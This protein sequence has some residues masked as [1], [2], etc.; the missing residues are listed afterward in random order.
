ME[1]SQFTSEINMLKIDG[2]LIPAKDIVLI[3]VKP[4]AD[5]M[6][7]GYD[8]SQFRVPTRQIADASIS[9]TV[10]NLPGETAFVKL[11]DLLCSGAPCEVELSDP[12]GMTIHV[13]CGVAQFEIQQEREEVVGADVILRPT[14]FQPQD[15]DR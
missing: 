3:L 8:F 11:R 7:V 6:L 4:E 15:T 1:L 14:C 5:Q 9:F 2:N 13:T 12:D 10:L